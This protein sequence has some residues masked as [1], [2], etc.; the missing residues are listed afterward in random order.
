MLGMTHNFNDYPFNGYIDNFMVWKT[1][2][3]NDDIITR[4]FGYQIASEQPNLSYVWRF[5]EG[6]GYSAADSS[7]YNVP[8]NWEDGNWANIQWSVCT[9]K[10][11]YPSAT[12]IVD[13]LVDDPPP[14]NVDQCRKIIESVPNIDLLGEAAKHQYYQ[15][16][17]LTTILTNDTKAGE[18]VVTPITDTL[19]PNRTSPDHPTTSLCNEYPETSDYYGKNCDVY[20]VRGA[21]D[22]N[23]EDNQCHCRHGF[24]GYGCSKTCLYARDQICG[25]G[26]CNKVTGQCTCSSEKFDPSKGCETCASGYIGVDCS[27][28]MAVIP[29][30]LSTYT[31]TCFGQG[32][33]EMFDGQMFEMRKSGEYLFFKKGTSLVV[34]VRMRPCDSCKACIQQVWFKQGVNDFTVKVPLLI[35]DPLI[36]EQDGKPVTILS[37]ASHTV[38]AQATVTWV[39]KV[40]LEFVFGTVKIA[41]SYVE[42]T[43][44]L[45][46]TVK[47]P[48]NSNDITGMLGNCNHNKDDDFKDASGYSVR[49]SDISNDVID[50]K[51]TKYLQ[52]S[53]AVA[54]KFVYTYPG[55]A[56]TEVKSMSQ[57][58]SVFINGSGAMT[59]RAPTDSF[60]SNA[61]FNV[62]VEARVKVLG[63]SGLIVGYYKLGSQNKF[64]LYL[65]G[66]RPRI[67]LY[68][69]IFDT[70]HEL[71]VDVWYHIIVAFDV[72]NTLFDMSIYKDGKQDFYASYTAATVSFPPE[73]NFLIGNW[74][75]TPPLNFGDYIGLIGELRIWNI[76]LDKKKIYTLVSDPAV[77]GVTGLVMQFRFPEGLGINTYDSNKG[78]P[79]KFSSSGTTAWII[80]DKQG[81]PMDTLPC[82][83]PTPDAERT[84]ECEEIF[85]TD[86]ITTAC[87]ALGTDT[88]S[89]FLDAC[90]NDDG[91]VPALSSYVGLCKNVLQPPTSPTDGLCDDYNSEHYDTFC[92]HMCMQGTPTSA[93]CKC[94]IGYW[95]WNCAQECP[96]RTSGGL[97]CFGNGACDVGSGNCIC[98]PGYDISTNCKTCAAPFTGEFC[99]EFEV[100]L[101][102]PPGSK[103]ETTG[104]GS[105]GDT[106]NGTNTGGGDTRW[107]RN[108]WNW[109]W[110]YLELEVLEQELM[111]LELVVLEQMALELAQELM[112]LELVV[113]ELEVLTQE[114]MVPGTGGT[115]TGG[116]GTGGNGTETGGT[117]TGGTGT[118]GTETGGTGTGGTGTG[119][120]GTGGTGT[121]GTGTG[122]EDPSGSDTNVIRTCA[123]YGSLS[124]LSFDS[125]GYAVGI[126]GEMYIVKPFWNTFPE[127]KMQSIKCGVSICLKSIQ[128]KLQD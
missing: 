124:A 31:A 108:W 18:E 90:K 54:N 38:N 88:S 126:A 30:T 43:S 28:V 27:S 111:V 89:F 15:E 121:G 70:D 83:A 35:N 93:G 125:I 119:G 29:S 20:C 14:E 52:I 68:G 71:E 21:G 5:N 79:M 48:C 85:A 45:S 110:W 44:Y 8:F 106:G 91:Y 6:T 13:V 47:T 120:T 56:L 67:H 115:G 64:S 9:Y 61:P 98:K 63:T 116:T 99:D 94:N 59:P 103:N 17:L 95:D 49:Y 53:S 12:D 66:R 40:T 75:I 42:D 84:A 86:S 57:G 127:V 51:F 26:T 118:G 74:E 101:P 2:E 46:V 23:V 100:V 37:L 77:T 60:Y 69:Q 78:I 11:E 107:N 80:S 19:E 72:K 128:I 4:A 32:H 24:Y 39:D 92:G 62:S 123:V 102:P 109:N 97:P 10:M 112:V 33:C 65:V 81:V 3:T 104:D 50:N 105:G 1:A 82:L 22:Y 34:Y 117:G 36:F 76:Y 7:P 41:M 25:G 87:N 96:D 58:F 73:G 114:Q 55:V 16:C 122:G 113:L